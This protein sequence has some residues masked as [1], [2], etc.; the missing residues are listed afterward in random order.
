M[1]LSLLLAFMGANPLPDF[2]QTGEVEFT[3]LS[4]NTID[5]TG[6]DDS[7]SSTDA[8]EGKVNPTDHS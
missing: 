3:L 2:G 8:E 6:V 1:L 4:Q 5:E 7:D